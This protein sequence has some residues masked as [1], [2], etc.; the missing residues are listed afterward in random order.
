MPGEIMRL[1]PLN[2]LRAFEAAARTGGYTG[3]AAELGVS[4]AA[5][6]Q[7][8]RNLEAFYGKRLFDRYSNR[9]ALTEAGREIHAGASD[10]LRRIAEMGSGA[11]AGP[12]R[13]RLRVSAP[14]SLVE[15]WL[16]SR[17]AALTAARPEIGVDIRVA[18]D[19]LDFEA[20]GLD[21]RV[22]FGARLYPG[23]DVRP[24]F[25]DRVAPMASPAFLARHGLSPGGELPELDPACFIQTNWGPSFA[26][27]PTW[28]DW[29][30]LSGRGRARE[31]DPGLT[32]GSSS[33]ALRLAGLGLGIALG[34]IELARDDLRS[35][36]LV[37]LHTDSLPF[38]HP[39]C[40][41][42]QPGRQK[43][44]SL[45]ALLDFLHGAPL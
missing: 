6:S 29:F 26:T 19:P 24:L 45:T 30:R 35:G 36:T 39:Y 3:A 20:E 11:A 18:D 4:P 16:A 1:P 12:R 28:A 44:A 14:P 7:Q 33:L 17:L 27:H 25:E 37:R 23:L 15:R 2:A 42:T 8:V 40:T 10:G 34:Q 38:G 5:V 41:V 32:A 31:I 21:L 13:S 9:V 22:C 43:G